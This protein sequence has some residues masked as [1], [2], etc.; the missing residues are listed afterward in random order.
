MKTLPSLRASRICRT[1]GV[2]LSILLMF[3]QAAR[4][5]TIRFEP[6]ASVNESY[7]DNVRSV[8]AGAEADF[9]TETSVGGR[10]TA[11]GNRLNLNLDFNASY[12]FSHNTKGLDGF[13][14]KV[15]GKGDAEFLKDKL[16]VDAFVSL[17]EV[18]ASRQGAQS[19]TNRSLP[20]K[21]WP[22]T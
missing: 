7:T 14:P 16:F 10:L 20:N 11:D 8:S 6:S 4:P 17:S 19:A 13:R 1:V 12:E 5:A 21:T 22:C 3:L 2:A 15:F 9:I 18:T